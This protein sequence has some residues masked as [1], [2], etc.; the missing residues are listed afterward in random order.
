GFGFEYMTRG[1]GVILGDPG[2]WL[3]AGMTGG[4][5]YLLVDKENGLTPSFIQTRIA[6]AAKVSLQP[7]AANDI[8]ELASLLS[9]AQNACNT[10]GC[11]VLKTQISQWSR[12]WS[13]HFIKLVPQGEQ[14][15]P[16]ISTE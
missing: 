6:P 16:S 9:T 8:K 13:Q 1:R 15:D 14:S 11:Q 7:L 10:E 3:A 5:L 2:P 4:V 12:D